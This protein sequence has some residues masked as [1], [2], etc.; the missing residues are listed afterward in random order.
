MKFV[1][2]RTLRY[3]VISCKLFPIRNILPRIN[4]SCVGQKGA[5]HTW[6]FSSFAKYLK[7]KH[8][9]F[10]YGRVHY[11]N[12]YLIAV[13]HGELGTGFKHVTPRSKINTLFSVSTP[14]TYLMTI[15]NVVKKP[16]GMN[17]K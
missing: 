11:L 14:C 17:N 8:S 7:N 15:V 10:K 1:V 16:Y 4:Y 3:I 5:K 9:F 12:C 2:Y 13:L 6:T